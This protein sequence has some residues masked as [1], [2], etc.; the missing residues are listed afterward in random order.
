[1]S[2]IEEPNEPQYVYVQQSKQANPI[3][4]SNN[5]TYI[6]NPLSVSNAKHSKSNS[7]TKKYIP[8]TTSHSP[9]HILT[10]DLLGNF[11][12]KDHDA[13]SNT[14]IKFST[15]A[16]P[17]EYANKDKIVV[18][19]LE[20]GNILNK[21]DSKITGLSKTAHDDKKISLEGMLNISN[22]SIK[23][24][25]RESNYYRRESEKIAEYIKQCKLC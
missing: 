11:Y 6:N 10:K 15:P 13:S 23:S 14:A 3:S 21:N 4:S 2:R 22:D 16:T 17:V 7:L 8:I 1:M 20:L 24:T 9:T 12:K 5:G 25:M 19:N 18:K